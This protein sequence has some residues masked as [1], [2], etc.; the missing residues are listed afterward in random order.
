MNATADGI[1]G[2][3]WNKNAF[4]LIESFISVEITKTS[5]HMKK[6]RLGM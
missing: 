1:C 6:T 5:V 4:Q 3:M 2:R